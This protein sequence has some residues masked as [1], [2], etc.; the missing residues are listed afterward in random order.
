MRV[1]PR[2]I[3]SALR[4]GSGK[5]LFSLGLIAALRKRGI[6]VTPFK[7]GPDYIDAGW[8][9]LAAGQPCRNL[10]TFFASRDQVLSSFRRHAVINGASVIEGNRGLYDGID[11][12]GATSTS[13]LAKLIQSPVILTLDCTKSTRTV[14]AMVLGCL[15]FDPDVMIRGVILNRI[16][17]PRHEKILSKSIEHYTGVKVIGAVPKLKK[18]TFPERHMGLIPTYESPEANQSIQAAAEV[19]EKYLDMVG[20]LEVA[21]NAPDVPRSET[22]KIEAVPIEHSNEQ[23]GQTNQKIRIGIIRDSAFQF[24]YPDNLEALEARGAELV[25]MSALSD[26]NIPEIDAMYIGGGFP[27]TQ[28]AQLS[29]N[30][31]F[32]EGLGELAK[33]GLPIYAE[34]GGLMYLGEELILDGESYPMAGVL[35]V[36]YGLSKRPEGHGYTKLTVDRENPY[37]KVGT[38]LRGHEFRYSKVLEWRGKPE[39]LAFRLERG[40]GF[41]EKRDGVCHKNVLGTYTHIHALGC[42]EWAEGVV[43]MGRR[44]RNG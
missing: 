27:E 19:A 6:F 10:D 1:F 33:N 16:A 12:E 38:R 34:C 15:R 17:G 42:P 37:F 29:A 40:R 26:P 28:A 44:A 21:S 32:R 36:T 31:S 22:S 18:N 43:R 11:L 3:I 2:L 7:K 9:A 41:Y 5:T 23:P 8:L 20:L 4:G 24:Y 25:F 30:I 39:D 35:P 13:E 14:A